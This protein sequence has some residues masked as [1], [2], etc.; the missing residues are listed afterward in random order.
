MRSNPSLDRY[1]NTEADPPG[2][3]LFYTQLSTELAY[4][5]SESPSQAEH[6][7]VGIEDRAKSVAHIEE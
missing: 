2:Q 6:K 5:R 7:V 1:T 4:L 3:L